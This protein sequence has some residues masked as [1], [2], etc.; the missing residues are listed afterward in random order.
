MNNKTIHHIVLVLVVLA[1]MP[2]ANADNTNLLEWNGIHGG[3]A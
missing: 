2:L 1:L 3:F